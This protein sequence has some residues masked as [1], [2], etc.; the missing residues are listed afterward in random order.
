M[1]DNCVI[2]SLTIVSCV[3][4][5]TVVLIQG[6][7]K[8]PQSKSRGFQTRC[9]WFSNPTPANVSL[10]DRD[11]EWIIGVQGGYQV[12]GDSWWPAF[13]SHQW[14]RTNAGEYGYGCVC[15]QLRVDGARHEVLEIKTSR[16]R[17]LASCRND[18]A[19]KKWK[20]L[21]K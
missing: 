14:V 9:G 15:M 12:D 10:F 8:L 19:L 20:D 18:S 2:R 3:L 1:I 17:S 16:S 4:L 13:K 11:A 7:P 5:I 6:S 21:F